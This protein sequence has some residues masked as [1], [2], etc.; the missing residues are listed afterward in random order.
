MEV[1]VT[2]FINFNHELNI[3]NIMQIKFNKKFL[4]YLEKNGLIINDPLS[5][6]KRK[7]SIES[8]FKLELPCRLP[9]SILQSK[10]KIEIGAFS[11]FN[12]QTLVQSDLK[13]GRWCSI[14]DDVKIGL[15]PHPMKEL[16]TSPYFYCKD[17]HRDWNKGY[18]KRIPFKSNK[19]VTIG[20][21]VLIGCGAMIKAGVTIGDG[22]SIGFGAKITKDVPPYAIVVND[23]E[24][25]GYRDRPEVVRSMNLIGTVK[26]WDYDQTEPYNQLLIKNLKPKTLNRTSLQK[27]Y[28]KFRW[29]FFLI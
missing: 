17:W 6:F 9:M 12:G 2:F 26:W 4:K 20:N 25:K 1:G 3:I 29:E 15:Q 18:K 16:S 14:A 27:L 5:P 13:M 11:Y 23:D 8:S 22:A 21:D 28:N 24:I 19:L 7:V 10:L